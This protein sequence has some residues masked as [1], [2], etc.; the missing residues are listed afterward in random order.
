MQKVQSRSKT[1]AMHRTDYSLRERGSLRCRAVEVP[2]AK[3]RWRKT[4]AKQ[5]ARRARTCARDSVVVGSLACS[6]LADC[7]LAQSPQDTLRR[8]VLSRKF[9]NLRGFAIK[10]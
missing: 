7:S 6:P 3:N 4:A 2:P 5:S 8:G 1:Q 9:R 10:K